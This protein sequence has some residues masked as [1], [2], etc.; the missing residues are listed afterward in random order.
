MIEAIK[1]LAEPLV[2]MILVGIPIG[3]I[4]YNLYCIVKDV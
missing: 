4:I 3:G 1:E 2:Q